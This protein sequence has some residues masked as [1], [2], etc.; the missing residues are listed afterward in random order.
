M[1]L[2]LSAPRLPIPARE[3]QILQE[4]HSRVQDAG[5]T[6]VDCVERLLRVRVTGGKARQPG[7]HIP[8]VTCVADWFDGFAK[9]SRAM[10][11]VMK[12]G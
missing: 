9:K 11:N 5:R 6:D 4:Q 2:C 1:F 10:I 3:R 7:L 8:F 12:K